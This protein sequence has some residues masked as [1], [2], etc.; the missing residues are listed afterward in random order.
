MECEARIYDQN[1]RC[2]LYYLPRIREDITI[3]GGTDQMCV[4]NVMRLIE[5]KTNGS[6]LC[7]CLP[8]CYA[9]N[10]EA[11]LS[12][13]PT[14]TQAIHTHVDYKTNV[15]RSY[16]TNDLAILHVFFKENSFRSQ[17]KE[18][19]IG[20][21]EFLCRFCDSEIPFPRSEVA[22]TMRIYIFSEYWWIV[23]TFHGLQCGF[24]HRIDL[25]HDIS[26]ILC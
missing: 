16:D 23:G 18:E 15:L 20:F 1:C 4:Q 2:I 12:S 14:L 19:L 8:S 13:A 5:S 25:F 21:T 7:N 11:E 9:I 3:C 6:F 10:Y 26:A 17:I 22:L 24:D